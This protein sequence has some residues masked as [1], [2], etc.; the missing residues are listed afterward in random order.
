[1]GE[2]GIAERPVDVRPGERPH[3]DVRAGVR[4]K[5]GL[6]SENVKRDA[7]AASAAWKPREA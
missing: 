5:Q 1:M 2:P 7:T 6:R 3:T 4:A